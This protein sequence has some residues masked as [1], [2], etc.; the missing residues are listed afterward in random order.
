MPDFAPSCFLTFLCVLIL[1][2]PYNSVSDVD[3]RPYDDDYIDL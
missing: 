1:S 2:T 3:S